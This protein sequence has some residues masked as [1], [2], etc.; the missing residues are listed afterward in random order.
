M[1]ANEMLMMLIQMM[2]EDNEVSSFF[3]IKEAVR[4][5]RRCK[6]KKY[7]ELICC[8]ET[9]MTKVELIEKHLYGKCEMQKLYKYRTIYQFLEQ[10]QAVSLDKENYIYEHIEVILDEVK[11]LDKQLCDIGDFNANGN[12]IAAWIDS[13]P[14]EAYHSFAVEGN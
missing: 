5:L 7:C 6:G 9:I 8:L 3:I 1:K 10:I 4:V 14:E 11:K 2:H 12:A 13:V